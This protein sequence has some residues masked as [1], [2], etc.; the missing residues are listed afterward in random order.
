[1]FRV[2]GI[3]GYIYILCVYG[4]VAKIL[5]CV[6][7]IVGERYC[8]V[9]CELLIKDSVLFCG[10]CMEQILFLCCGNCRN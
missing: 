4:I 9:L 5:L 10:N 1:M 8:F 3:V 7:G 2:L 6:V